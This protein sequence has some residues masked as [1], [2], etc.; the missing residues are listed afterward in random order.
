[1]DTVSGTG[2]GHRA[3]E[4]GRC[5]RCAA[6]SRS[7][8]QQRAQR[9]REWPPGADESDEHGKLVS[10][11]NAPSN[12]PYDAQSNE[13]C[14]YSTHLHT[15]CNGDCGAPEHTHH[16]AHPACPHSQPAKCQNMHR[17]ADRQEQHKRHG[18]L[19]MAAAQDRRIALPDRWR[20]YSRLAPHDHERPSRWA[21]HPRGDG[22]L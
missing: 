9:T 4:S 2:R 3:G 10:R 20:P 22:R 5:R 21:Q 13:H 7:G 17:D 18:G 19:D 11:P 14:T 1:M 8:P 16:H 6:A 15:G 12:T